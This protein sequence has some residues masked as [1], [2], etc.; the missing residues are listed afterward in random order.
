MP[1]EKQMH[2]VYYRLWP[3]LA[4]DV[5]PD[6]MDF[7]QFIPINASTTMI[8][9]VPFALKDERR[10]MKV[11]RYLN[12]RINR[13]V[14]AEDT[15]LINWVQEG[16]ETSAFQSGPLAKTEICLIDS[17]EKIRKAIPVSRLD[18]EPASEEIQKLNREFLSSSAST[19]K[20]SLIHPSPAG[21]LK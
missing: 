1:N 10:E 21:D 5:Y 13:D 19:N 14:N 18:R 12:W 6:Q 3:N 2:W 9:E 20:I 11:A 4:F 7:M 17:A 16:M 8:R 15:D